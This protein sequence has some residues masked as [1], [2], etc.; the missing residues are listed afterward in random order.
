MVAFRAISSALAVAAVTAPFGAL[1]NNVDFSDNYVQPGYIQP[2]HKSHGYNFDHFDLL[3]GVVDA[4]GDVVE[5]VLAT[6]GG[7][8][9]HGHK[10]NKHKYG[11]GHGVGI[12]GGVDNHYHQPGRIYHSSGKPFHILSLKALCCAADLSKKCHILDCHIKLRGYDKP[13][14]GKKI[15]D[16]DFYVPKSYNGHNKNVSPID[17]D[18]GK[19]GILNLGDHKRGFRGVEIEIELLDLLKVE[20]DTKQKHRG[21]YSY[22]PSHQHGVLGLGL[23]VGI[24]I[25]ID[26]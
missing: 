25:N 8:L 15:Y 11:N 26:L 19:D 12:V 2:L 23:I 24:D 10:Q 16:H 5:D 6:V 1:A 13:N 9:S 18:V 4:V 21:R 7:V 14:G 3:G 22:K 20:V 17:I